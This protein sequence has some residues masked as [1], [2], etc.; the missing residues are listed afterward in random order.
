MKKLEK[1]INLILAG[2]NPIG[3]DGHLALSEYSVYIKPLISAIQNNYTEECI[4]TILSN[5]GL[6]FDSSDENHIREVKNLAS[7]FNEVY[8]EEM[9][10][11]N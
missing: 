5:M 2:W 11:L 1:H 3:V 8:S 10:L 6:E 9:K 7:L 4:K